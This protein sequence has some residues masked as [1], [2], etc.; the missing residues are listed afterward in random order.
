MLTKLPVPFWQVLYIVSQVTQVLPSTASHHGDL[1]TP[2]PEMA[3]ATVAGRGQ[4]ADA[5]TSEDIP[6]ITSS[7]Q[8]STCQGSASLLCNITG[9]MQLA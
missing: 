6:L 5:M 9:Q 4:W 2:D 7:T 3:G 8:K 1:K